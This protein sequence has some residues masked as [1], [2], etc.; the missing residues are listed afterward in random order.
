LYL[1]A[2]A[3]GELLTGAVIIADEVFGGDAELVGGVERDLGQIF[4]RNLERPRSR[5]HTSNLLGGS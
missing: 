4:D 5:P 1:A 3:A 2:E